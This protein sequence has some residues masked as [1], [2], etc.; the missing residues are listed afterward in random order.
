MGLGPDLT[1][2]TTV[3]VSSD[4]SR[5][6]P[7]CNSSSRSGWSRPLSD[8]G[9]T[10]TYPGTRW[11]VRRKSRGVLCLS[12]CPLRTG[13]LGLGGEPKISLSAPPLSS[14]EEMVMDEDPRVIPVKSPLRRFTVPILT[15]F[16]T[17]SLCTHYKWILFSFQRSRELAPTRNETLLGRRRDQEKEGPKQRRETY[18]DGEGRVN[19]REVRKERVDKEVESNGAITTLH[20]NCHKQVK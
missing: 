6:W 1:R 3:T 18:T 9:G 7:S 19:R 2:S 4:D 14:G 20:I 13:D 5:G 15:N 17:E 11:C 16:S 10:R 12:Q 8:P